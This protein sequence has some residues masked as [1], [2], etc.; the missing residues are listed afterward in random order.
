MRLGEGLR[1]D[2]PSPNVMKRLLSLAEVHFS[3]MKSDLPED[4]MEYSHFKRVVEKLDWN[5]SPGYPYMKQHPNNRAFFE[6]VDGVPSHAALVKVWQ[7]VN[8]RLQSRDSD[9]VRL[10]IKKEPHKVS[11]R[12]KKAWR[13]ISSVSVVDQI[14]DHMLLDFI[15]DKAVTSYLDNSCKVGWTPYGGGWKYVPRKGCYAAD[16]T[17]WDWSV[18]PWLLEMLYKLNVLLCKSGP[19]KKR[20]VELYAWR[21]RELY[22]NTVFVTSGGLKIRQ[23]YPG[24]QK[25]GCVDTLVGNSKMQWLL[26]GRVCLEMNKFITWL[27]S[28]GDDTLQELEWLPEEVD[29][30]KRRLS[31]FCHL[32]SFD[33]V[34]EFAGCRFLGSRVEPLY[35]GKHSYN[36]LHANEANF[37]EMAVSYALLYHRSVYRDFIRDVLESAGAEIPSLNIL[38]VIFD[39]E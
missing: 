33:K 27:M 38:D 21:F 30:Y 22:F 14:I 25:S 19:H 8:A 20:W 1:T 6:V 3:C 32:K 13:L 10:F 28:M 35:R 12:D 15:N 2:P 7:L 34:S 39:G 5:S 36:L 24:V 9:P 31:E 37:D 17:G 16:K 23:R 4:F 11:K 18:R 26:H 29:D